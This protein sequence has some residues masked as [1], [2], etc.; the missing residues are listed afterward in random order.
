MGGGAI[1]FG[2]NAGRVQKSLFQGNT[3]AASLGDGGGA[4]FIQYP[5]SQI[6]DTSTFYG[7]SSGYGG[8]IALKIGNFSP[9]IRN[10]TFVNNTATHTAGG[11]YAYFTGTMNLENNILSNNTGGNCGTNVAGIIASLGHNIDSGNTCGFTGLGDLVNTDPLVVA[12]GPAANGG[13]TKT[14]AL[15]STSPA[16][17][18]GVISGLLAVDQRGNARPNG[19]QCDIGAYEY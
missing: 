1:M 4:I 3:A 13:L 2:T 8:A 6:I 5:N 9:T 10:N 18:A 16:R 14:I 15:Q 7:N 11:I 17:D 19:G 12:G